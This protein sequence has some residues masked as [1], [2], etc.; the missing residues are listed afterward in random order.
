M[1]ALF[2]FGAEKLF[3]LSFIVVGYFFYKLPKEKRIEIII[4]TFFTLPLAFILGEFARHLYVN[5]RPFVVRGFEPLISHAPDNGFPSDHALLLSS[6]AAIVSFFSRKYALILWA[7]TLLVSLSR[8]YA[9]LHHSI[10]ILGS[11]LIALLSA[12][13]VHVV[14]SWRK[15]V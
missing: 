6:I 1:D 5:P 9:G 14:L 11:I 12:T 4:F 3:I 10:D 15:S 13:V 8:M 7:I 2:I